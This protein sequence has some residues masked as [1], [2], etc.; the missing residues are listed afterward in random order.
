MSVLSGFSIYNCTNNLDSYGEYSLR[1]WNKCFSFIPQFTIIKEPIL[2]SKL[3]PSAIDKCAMVF[4]L[5]LACEKRR[6]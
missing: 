5:P 4:V 6:N 1:I 2:A 3:N